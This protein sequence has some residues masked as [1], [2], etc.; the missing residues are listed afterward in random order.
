MNA[1]LL[2]G[3]LVAWSLQAAVLV[4]VSALVS[5][6][7]EHARGRFLFW[8][9]VLAI[10]L[11]L[12]VAVPWHQP[13]PEAIPNEVGGSITA[14]A[15][16]L[17][18][19]PSS[20][21]WSLSSLFLILGAGAV[22]RLI[23][24]SAGLVRLRR[25]RLQATQIPAPAFLFG[26]RLRREVRWY[27][28][29]GI[30]GPVTFGWVRPS[31]LLPARVA[32][33]PAS[34]REAILCHELVHIERRDWPFVLFEELIRAV[35]WF[36]PAVWFALGQLQLAREESVDEEVVR[37]TRDHEGYVEALLAVAAQRLEPDVAPAPL[38]LKK[39]H[40][41]VRVAALVSRS[42]MEGS[43]STGRLVSRFTATGLA[44]AASAAIAVWLFPLQSPA[45]S[46]PDDPGI[47][48]DPGARL[49]HRAPLHY[50]RAATLGG[51]VI[52][53]ASL[54]RNGEVTDARV[55]S[56]PGELRRDALSS[57]L[58]WHYAGDGAAPPSARVSIQYAQ[59]A[60]ATAA[61]GGALPPAPPPPPPP[62]AT[63]R[64]LRGV[65][66][67]D[68]V[69][70]GIQYSG[71]SPDLK[72]RIEDRL[73]MHAGDTVSNEVL[74]G[75]GNSLR[76][77][78]DHLVLGVF[79]DQTPQGRSVKLQ[80]SVRGAQI[81]PPVRP[82]PPPPPPPPAGQSP[83][84]M[85]GGAPQRINLSGNVQ[86]ANLVTKITPVYPPLAKQARIQGSV[87]MTA[88]IGTEGQVVDLQLVSGHPLL[89][90]A[91]M[92]AVRQWI[93]RPTLL[94]GQPVEVIT[95]IDVNFTLAQ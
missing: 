60:A 70:S 27:V 48:V 64:E 52:V 86:T 87:R 54:D 71:L 69:L 80:I 59:R 62:G 40:L 82:A 16:I 1:S 41:A 67:W 25:V 83:A 29:D 18:T 90:E 73:K 93:Y 3:N 92:D 14:T 13:P 11:L 36:H 30:S 9:G 44:A 50:P 23:W 78:D 56:G 81:A 77:I 63:R 49:L 66:G 24:I 35:L 53:D 91:A 95:Q 32:A 43:M 8:R 15:A 84:A 4:A 6:R 10:A 34:A 55:L 72:Q 89:A 58:Q 46:L 79:S 47:T 20:S 5:L 75:I 37:R 76:E 22:L 57:V 28:S 85:P 94:N 7:W 19:G 88:I 61:V 39:R 68:G 38:F 17:T 51:T 2:F 45:Q 31:V 65:E 12:P 42:A 74:I 21:L 26:E 33:L